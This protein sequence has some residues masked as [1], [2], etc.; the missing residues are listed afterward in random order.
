MPHRV[1]SPLSYTTRALWGWL[2]PNG[3]PCEHAIA[4][5]AIQLLS[6]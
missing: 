3:V 5:S 1:L 2:T 4:T 6:V